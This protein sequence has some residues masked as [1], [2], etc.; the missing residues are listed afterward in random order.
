MSYMEILKVL[1]ANSANKLRI[2]NFT[3]MQ[4]LVNKIFSFTVKIPLCIVCNV[5]KNIY[6]HLKTH[7]I[8]LLHNG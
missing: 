2:Y 1:N 5:N 7:I 3:T 4:R 8:D 6:V